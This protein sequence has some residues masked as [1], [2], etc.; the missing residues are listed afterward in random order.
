L[1]A[2]GACHGWTDHS[3]A[4]SSWS[5]LAHF[6]EL[7]EIHLALKRSGMLVY[8]TPETEV[9][10]RSDLTSRGFAKYYD[11]VVMIRLAGR[12]CKFALE[13]ERTPKAVHYY[14]NIRQRIEMEASVTRFLYLVEIGGN[15]IA[16]AADS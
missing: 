8:W 7:N 14:E 15:R 16:A 6:L 3:S 13:Y 9:R 12:D 4:R 10:S 11:A 2:Q 5:P 1:I